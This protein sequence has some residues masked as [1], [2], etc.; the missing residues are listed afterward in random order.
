VH[1][2][3]LIEG[4][5]QSQKGSDRPKFHRVKATREYL[6][7][8]ESLGQ[9]NVLLCY[10]ELCEVTHPA[11]PSVM[12]FLKSHGDGNVLSLDNRSDEQAIVD[13]C[14]RYSD[15]L[16]NL[17]FLAFTPA[18]VCLKLVNLFDLEPARIGTR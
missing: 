16:K 6:T 3:G 2:I 5:Q 10:A 9:P 12:V 18:L 13:F 4:C 8:L 1:T 14:T 7:Q 11:L 17:P 15:V